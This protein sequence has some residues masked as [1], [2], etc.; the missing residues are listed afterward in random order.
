MTAMTRALLVVLSLV[1]ALPAHAASH[2]RGLVTS[3]SG[4]PIAGATVTALYGRPEVPPLPPSGGEESQTTTGADGRYDLELEYPGCYLVR[5][6]AAGHQALFFPNVANSWEA[7]CVEVGAALVEGIDLQLPLAGAISGRITDGRTGEPLAGAVVSAWSAFSDTTGGGEPPPGGEPGGEPGGVPGGEP[8]QGGDPGQGGGPNHGGG[9]P[10][11]SWGGGSAVTDSSGNYLIDGLASGDYLVH[12]EAEGHIAEFYPDTQNP[13]EATRIAVESG[14]T[15]SGIDLTLGRGGCI[16]GRVTDQRTGEPIAGA[17][18]TLGGRWIPTEPPPPGGWPPDGGVVYPEPNFGVSTD[19]DGR[20]SLCGLAPGEYLVFAGAQSY[21]GEYFDNAACPDDADLVTVADDGD[22]LGIDF[23][24]GEG[25]RIAGRVLDG[26]APVSGALVRAWPA[27]AGDSTVVPPWPGDPGQGGPGYPG[28]CSGAWGA[29]AVTDEAGN[30][31]LT[32]L[33]TGRYLVMA[34]APDFLPTFHGGGQDPQAATPVEV[35]APGTVTG[36]DIVLERGGAIAGLVQDAETGAPLEGIGVE[37]YLPIE[38]GPGPRW[39]L[40]ATTDATGAYR[41]TGVPA[42]EHTVLA[43]AW[44]RGYELEFYRDASTPET[45]TPVAVVP[46]AETSGID[47][48]LTRLRPADGAIGGRVTGEDGQPITGAV[49]T[50]ISLSGYAGIGV[51]DS[52]GFYWIS[53]LPADEYVVLAAAAGHVGLFYQQALSW[54]DATPVRVDGPVLGIDFALA[55]AGN[56]RGVISGRVTDARGLA[57]PQAGVY[58]EPEAGTAPSGFALSGR[59]GQF[60]IAGLVPGRYRIRATR[61][62]MADAYAPAE[63]GG[64]AAWI[65][66]AGQPIIGLVVVLGAGAPSPA[67]LRAEPSVPNPFHDTVAI[68]LV[69]DRA[70]APIVIDLYSVSGRHVRR[71]ELTAENPGRH[72]ISWNGRDT[73]GALLPSGVYIYRAALAGKTVSGRLV[74]V[75]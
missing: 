72:E 62:G 69:S 65:T 3:E 20:Y 45:A 52:T 22:V 15:V 39:Y 36:I 70:Q 11:G 31:L 23:A 8:G 75:R 50:A 64:P 19:P 74:I 68:R 32:G 48:T 14:T 4:A 27:A 28:D 49:V 2:I 21:L 55:A 58:A 41:I 67:A 26:A 38:G 59:D 46:P 34:E 1:V 37:I 25:A 30:Y 9:N 13:E 54:E 6:T 43:T 56:G 47:F 17:F 63:P 10:D 35:S 33:S 61:P 12:A 71:L 18:V 44:D 42:G 53:S 57:V 51:A 40:A 7:T 66:V 5:A 16:Q 60:A 73:A 29:E 24:L